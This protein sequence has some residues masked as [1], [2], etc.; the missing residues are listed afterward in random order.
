[1]VTIDKLYNAE[2]DLK[3]KDELKTL[4]CEKQVTMEVKRVD[5]LTSV[6]IAP[7]RSK[8]LGNT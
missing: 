7:T 6:C 4:T 2:R 8:A 5:T 3:Y 1:V